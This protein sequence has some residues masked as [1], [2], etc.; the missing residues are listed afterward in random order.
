[1]VAGLIAALSVGAVGAAE[2][3][4]RTTHLV[5][6]S[7]SVHLVSKGKSAHVL[8]TLKPTIVGVDPDV[9]VLAKLVAAGTITQVQ[10]N[11]VLVALQAARPTRPVISGM[12][13][14]SGD[15]NGLEAGHGPLGMRLG[16]DVTAITSTLGISAAQ[17]QTDLAAGQSLATIAGAKTPA[18]ISALVAAETIKIN[19]A[20]TAGTLTQ[21]QATTLIAGLT[22]SVT[23]IV[24]ATPGVGG[25][26]H[27]GM[28]GTMG[29]GNNDD[30]GVPS[31]TGSN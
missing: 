19:A 25:H 18:L 21:A 6:S 5:S 24:N 3:S 2:A 12:G 20:V 26:G 10:S 11:A 28:G 29:N 30:S 9:A 4:S 7:K 23:A 17:L 1:M 15:D 22:A 13:G 31:T 8:S 27:M 16:A 14:N